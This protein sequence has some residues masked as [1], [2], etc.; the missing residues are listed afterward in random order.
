M[1]RGTTRFVPRLIGKTGE[2]RRRAILLALLV[3]GLAAAGTVGLAGSVAAG[4]DHPSSRTAL[5]RAELADA[6]AATADAAFADN[7]P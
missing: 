2:M 1:R 7:R 3:G 6:P 4:S 5:A